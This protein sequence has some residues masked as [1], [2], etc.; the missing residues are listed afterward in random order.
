MSK[1][2]KNLV[3]MSE[4]L[5]HKTT[6]LAQRAL[7]IDALHRKVDL[8]L[9]KLESLE[10]VLDAR[11]SRT[12]DELRKLEEHVDRLEL[13]LK[14]LDERLESFDQR[15]NERLAISE[16]WLPEELDSVIRQAV[17]GEPV[18]GAGAM[19]DDDDRGN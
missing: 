10:F 16:P 18:G 11:A 14:S 4:S 13:I 8:A 12:E 15:F 6:A 19:G 3:S 9:G 5:R 17:E 1:S 2:A 7:A